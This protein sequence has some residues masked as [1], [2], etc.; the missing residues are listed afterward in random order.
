MKPVKYQYVNDVGWENYAESIA[1]KPENI[2]KYAD[3][4][5][6]LVPIIQHAS[7]DYLADPT[8]GRGHHPRRRGPVRC[9]LRVDVRCGH[10]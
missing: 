9:R 10:G 3:C 5:K 4:F 6:L 7:I 1:T 2:T 8:R